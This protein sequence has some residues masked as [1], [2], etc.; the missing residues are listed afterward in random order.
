MKDEQECFVEKRM[1]ERK[2]DVPTIAEYSVY[3]KWVVFGFCGLCALFR[4]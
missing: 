4:R 3:R 1:Q 2:R